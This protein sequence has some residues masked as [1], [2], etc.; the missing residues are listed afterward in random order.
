[1]YEL[2]IKI[3]LSLLL[4]L[5]QYNE[6]HELVKAIMSHPDSMFVL[7][8]NS[9]FKFSYGIQKKLDTI[10]DKYNSF[11][12]LIRDIK[13]D[14]IGKNLKYYERLG[15]RDVNNTNDPGYGNT[16]LP[17]HWIVVS[18]ECDYNIEFWWLYVNKSWILYNISIYTIYDSH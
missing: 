10:N 5:S 11:K 15:W 16:T 9:N 4:I 12:Y 3:T 17:L 1:M 8:K 18:C 13:K 2:F 6:K 7:I 14:F